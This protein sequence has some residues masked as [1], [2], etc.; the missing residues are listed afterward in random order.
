MV[1]RA[2]GRGW[3]GWTFSPGA[4]H[5]MVCSCVRVRAWVALSLS[6]LGGWMSR[7]REVDEKSVV[8]RSRERLTNRD[9]LFMGGG[10]LEGY[11]QA[12]VLQHGL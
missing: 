3:I 4:K 7:W 1:V 11:L 9:H 8:H 6:P 12:C 5:G 2:C 10:V